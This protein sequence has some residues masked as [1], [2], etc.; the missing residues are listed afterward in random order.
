MRFFDVLEKFLLLEN[1]DNLDVLD[2][3]Q[4][5][6]LSTYT[7]DKSYS[8]Q[9]EWRIV[10]PSDLFNNLQDFPFIKSV[11]LGERM[12]KDYKDRIIAV[13]REKA[14]PIYQRH[15]NR[16]KSKIIIKAIK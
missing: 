8:F 13:A 12:D 7:K 10:L 16:T 2:E 6:F 14:I 1:S 4:K 5:W 9:N 11:T 15:Y 3:Y